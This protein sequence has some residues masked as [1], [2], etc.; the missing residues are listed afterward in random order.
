VE[1]EIDVTDVLG[2]SGSAGVGK[3]SAAFEI[4]HQLEQLGVT[5]ALIDSDEL[6]R[7]VPVPDDL[8]RLTERNLRCV[9]AGF[10]DRGV[11]RLILVGV[12]LHRPS[13][14]AWIARAV[15]GA[16]FTLVRLVASDATLV[17]RIGRREI[18]SGGPSQLERTRRQVRSFDREARPDVHLI[19]TDGVPVAELATEIIRR[20]DWL[21][22]R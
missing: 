17:E 13:E 5:H 6:D 4:S 12:F 16:R 11:R 7:I 3:S 20:S 15:P 10:H 21:A 14:L 2:I 8:W 9:W 18:G 1:G 19:Q 22:Q